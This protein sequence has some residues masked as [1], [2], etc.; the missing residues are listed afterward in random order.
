ME[1]NW[2]AK[3]FSKVFL[4][5]LILSVSFAQ[6]GDK[7]KGFQR[8]CIGQCMQNGDDSA[9]LCKEKCSCTK[10]CIK[11]KEGCPSKKCAK[12]FGDNCS[13]FFRVT[14]CLVYIHLQRLVWWNCSCLA[15]LL[16]YRIAVF[17][18]LNWKIKFLFN[19]DI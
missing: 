14:K 12:C 1:F 4:L 8:Y 16:V 9:L 10:E 7:G 17:R 5:Q 15:V 6:R 19:L 2:I 11:E 13:H 18:S 3:Y